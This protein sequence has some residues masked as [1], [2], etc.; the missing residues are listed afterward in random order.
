MNEKLEELA[1]L[2]SGKLCKYCRYFKEDILMN[3]FGWCSL[4]RHICYSND[5]CKTIEILLEKVKKDAERKDKSDLQ[6]AKTD[7]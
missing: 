6:S 2:M 5:S 3:G 1:F 4:D 7:I